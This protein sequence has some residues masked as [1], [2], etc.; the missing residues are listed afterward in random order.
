MTAISLSPSSH[1]AFLLE[2]Y[3]HFANESVGSMPDPARAHEQPGNGRVA[4]RSRLLAAGLSH[5]EPDPIGAL[6]RSRSSGKAPLRNVRNSSDADDVD[7]D[8][9]PRCAADHTR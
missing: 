1:R 2:H 6:A 7:M 4:G 9:S 3:F 5:Y 8:D